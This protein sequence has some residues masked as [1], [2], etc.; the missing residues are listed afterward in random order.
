LSKPFKKKERAEKERMKYPEVKRKKAQ[1]HRAFGVFRMCSVKPIMSETGPA[2]NP[3]ALVLVDARQPD[4]EA[5]AFLF[6]GVAPLRNFLSRSIS[7]SNSLSHCPTVNSDNFE[8]ITL[9]E[10]QST[11]SPPP[12]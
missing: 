5:H 11:A 2:S 8:T 4:D 9:E 3:A 10:N 6:F 1:L 7:L 12:K